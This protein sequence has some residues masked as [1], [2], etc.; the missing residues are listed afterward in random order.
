MG[1]EE[2]TTDITVLGDAANTAARLSTNA[3]Q[4]EILVS[5]ATAAAAGLDKDQLEHRTLKLRGKEKPF[6][7]YV[8]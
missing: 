6:P 5:E 4:G 2:G 7:V 1:S 8:L 3:K